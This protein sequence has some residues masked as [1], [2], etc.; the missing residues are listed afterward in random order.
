MDENFY[1]IGSDR[2]FMLNIKSL[3]NKI[4]DL[5]IDNQAQM[6]DHI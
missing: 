3:P 5:K 2:L 1:R 6:S 4:T